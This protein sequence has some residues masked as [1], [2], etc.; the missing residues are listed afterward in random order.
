MEYGEHCRLAQGTLDVDRKTLTALGRAFVGALVFALPML[1]TMELWFMGFYV[2]P[3]KLMLLLLVSIPLL[4]GLSRI[5]G[6]EPTSSW[7]DDLVDAFVA[8]FIAA[9]M[10]TVI[11]FL[12]G[13]VTV[14]MPLREIAGKIILQTFPGSFGAV[15]A[16][17]TLGDRPDTRSEERMRT[18]P[19]ALL[20]MTAGAIFLGLNLA[21]TEEIILL[22]HT[23]EPARE[24][25]LAALSLLIMHGIVYALSFRGRPH[26]LP[27][28]AFFSLF[29]RYT[30]PGYAI[31]LLISLYLLWTFGRTEG[32]QWDEI[33]SACVV[34]GFPSAIG[35]AVSRL[36]V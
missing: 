8:I 9:L 14:E 1:M 5:V 29:V 19:G 3:L 17:G 35:A 22:A 4:T 6:F 20:L 13:I 34:L 32:A 11:L 16:R 23:M 28:Q 18:Y 30:L 10:A 25:A 15:L 21:P 27:D 12:F 7:G 26:V 31:V 36:I 33:A 2:D 24:I